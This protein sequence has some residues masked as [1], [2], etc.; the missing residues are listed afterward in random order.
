M[1]ALRVVMAVLVSLAMM[2]IARTNSRG[3]PEHII[4]TDGAYT[5]EMT[6][7]PK[8][9]ENQT[10]RVTVRVSGTLEGKRVFF[11]TSQLSGLKPD[12][13]R[14]F[15]AVEMLPVPD[16][17]GEFYVDVTAGE[18]GG[19]FHYYFEVVDAAG[20]RQAG[21]AAKNGEPFSLRYIGEVP[22]PVLVGHIFFIFATVFC[23]SLATVHAV[24]VI[25]GHDALGSM[26]RCLA[27]A[28]VCCFIGGYPLG[29]SM[30]HF[31]FNGLWEGVP[32]GTDATDNKT[33]LLLI[34]LLFAALAT[35]G[36]LSRGRFGRDLF[37]PR[38]LGW[39]G[40]GTFGVMLFIYLIP[41]SIQFS[42]RFTYAFCYTWIA[43]V[44]AL[45]VWG[46]LRSRA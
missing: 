29:W 23:I 18:R 5:L 43:V 45:Y 9:T 24:R 4:H 1:K 16:Y 7:L 6:T 27:L 25:G 31:A 2:Y 44:V 33:Q 12:R 30:N 40:L 26:A 8:V 37:A 34:Y 22:V 13:M 20:V 42:A 10:G 36:S 41:H 11:R 17:P 32:F 28:V 14:D 46:L 21:F 35:L 15:A 19:R 3:Q 38:T 39:I